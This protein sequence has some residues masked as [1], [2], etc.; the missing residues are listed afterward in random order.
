MPH[1][2]G[3]SA[4]QGW[5]QLAELGAALLLSALIGLEREFRQKSAGLRT[6][7]LVGFGAGL[8]M[9]VSKYGFFDLLQPGRVILDPSRVAAQIVSGIGFI[10]AGIIF[11]R[12]DTVQGLTTAASVWVTA[13]VGTACGA[14]LT[15]LAA[16]ATVGYFFI[17]LCLRQVTHHLNG[18]SL[19]TSVVTVRYFDGR[20]TLREV[21]ARTCDVGFVIGEVLT[22]AIGRDAD[23]TAGNGAHG[24]PLATTTSQ[25]VEVSL[26]LRGKGSITDLA[27]LLSGVDGVVSINAGTTD[28]TAGDT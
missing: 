27:T 23:G 11:V 25:M 14:G 10:G 3:Q 1:V 28:E 4:G 12:R 2:F 22:R 13:A 6:H 16:A 21:L 17:A 15:M 24:P 20:G 7:T 5:Q 8:F 9:L 19:T 26:Q 18:S